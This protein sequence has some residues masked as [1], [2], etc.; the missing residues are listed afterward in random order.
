MVKIILTSC[1][2]LLRY[3]LDQIKIQVR[4]QRLLMKCIL[5]AEE[6]LVK[7]YLPFY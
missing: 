3:G 2:Q 5:V 1:I 7:R 6:V 4:V